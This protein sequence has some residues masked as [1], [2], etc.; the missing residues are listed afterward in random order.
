[1]KSWYSISAKAEQLTT[2][3][4]IF[5]EI[6]YWGVTAK[7]FITDLKTVPSNHK[8]LLRIHSPGGEV[9]DGN[10]IANALSRH[11]GG[12][13]AQIEGLAAS[14]ATVISLSGRPVKMAANGFYMIH[15]P[16]GI[17]LG[18]AAGMREQAELLDKIQGGIVNAY[19]AK[20]GQTP[21]QIQ[22]WMDAET[23]FTAQE[24]KD[25]GFVDEITDA[26]K[27]AASINKFPRM[28][29]F[30][31]AP[32]SRELLNESGQVVATAYFGKPPSNLTS[33]EI[34]MEP[35]QETETP[36]VETPVVET[37]TEETAPVVETPEEETP[38]IPVEEVPETPV[39][40]IASADSILAKFAAKDAMIAAKDIQI[41]ALQA[42][43]T[44]SDEALDR[45]ERSLGV[46]A[47]KV[48][49]AVEPA[50]DNPNILTREQFSKITPA[51]KKE[52]LKN[53]GTLID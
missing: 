27:M 43:I 32:Q 52:F 38:E 29:K 25:A 45:L 6:G 44:A 16:W 7:D 19:V 20:S 22:S 12:Y 40:V 24:A 5:D 31:N 14:M 30:K 33:A 1:M 11:P 35:V 2:E 39:A 8:I 23:W 4:S 53:G 28:E 37:P 21:E 47:A 9:F 48:V 3:I 42:R 49:P 26:H 36:I 17:A 10:A 50:N 51:A 18:D 15:N 13:E 46:A 34:I 41:N